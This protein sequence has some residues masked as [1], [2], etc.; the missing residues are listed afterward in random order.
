MTAA[1]STA[2]FDRWWPLAGGQDVRDQVLAAYASPSRGYHDAAHLAEV[3]ARVDELWAAAPTFDRAVVLLAAWFHDA[4]YDAL[5]DDEQRSADWAER[6]LPELGVAPD[7]VA[8]VSALVRMTATHRPADDDPEAQALCDADLAI[9]AA[10]P[11]RYAHYVAA[12]REEYAHVAE[13]DFRAG[14]AAILTDLIAKPH[15]FHTTHARRHWEAPARVNV[16]R[17]L[18]SLVD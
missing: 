7:V 8:R 13:P 10:D 12:V 3:C 4:V 16:Q 1:A 9:L 14:R 18:R 6:A 5:P 17:E 15:L 11:T 2:R